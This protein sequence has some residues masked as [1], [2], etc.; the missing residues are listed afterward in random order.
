MP[1][2]TRL[3]LDVPQPRYTARLSGWASSEQP[4]RRGR[5]SGAPHVPFWISGGLLVCRSMSVG[6]AEEIWSIGKGIEREKAGSLDRIRS[7]S[8]PS[9]P[10]AMYIKLSR[11]DRDSELTIGTHLKPEYSSPRQYPFGFALRFAKLWHCFQDS[12]IQWRH[13][14]AQAGCRDS[15]YPNQ[16][17]SCCVCVCIWVVF[18]LV[19]F[20]FLDTQ[21]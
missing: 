15:R 7:G 5:F 2:A 19:F 16:F 4:R 1:G 12:K 6:Y 3:F 13:E 11:K 17:L 18:F 20:V 8:D 10:S 14:P 21:F 9:V